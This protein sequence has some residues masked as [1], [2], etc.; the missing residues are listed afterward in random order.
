M[1]NVNLNPFFFGFATRVVPLLELPPVFFFVLLVWGCSSLLSLSLSLSLSL[2]LSLSLLSPL[3]LFFFV[4]LNLGEE[5]EQ[6]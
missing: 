2:F 5:T 6:G 4:H 1:R 3:S